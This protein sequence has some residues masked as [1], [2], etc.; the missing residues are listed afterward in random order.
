MDML[1]LR[2]ERKTNMATNPTM[3]FKR[4]ADFTHLF[5]IPT[6][7]WV[8]GGTLWFTAKPKVDNDASD[9]AAVINKSFD[10]T[11]IATVSD[12]EY[13]TGY[14]TYI[15]QFAPADIVNISFAN[16]AKK[17][18]YLGEFTF[19]AGGKEEVFPSNDDYIDTIIYADIKVGA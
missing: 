10:D 8:A 5:Q 7:S 16:G 3:T 15:L 1:Q 4:G 18:K 12:D 17:N 9:T 14:V 2:K 6:D 11:D 19:I 13:L